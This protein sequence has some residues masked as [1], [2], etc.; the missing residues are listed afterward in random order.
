MKKLTFLCV[1]VMVTAAL[2]FSSENSFSQV[3]QLENPGFEEWDNN[4]EPT[5]WNS[6]PSANCTLGS[7]LCGTAAQT[8][9]E[10]SDDVRPGSTGSSCKIFSTSVS[11]VFTTITANGAL[12]SGQMQITNASASNV[13]NCNKTIT[14]SEE[15]NHR[16]NAKP[17][18]IV[19]WA[20]VVNASDDSKACCHLCIHD[21]YD[22]KD[23]LAANEN[24]YQSHIVGGVTSYDFAN[25]GSM[26]QRHSTPIIYE[27]YSCND[28]QFVLITFSTNKD[29]GGGSGGD[30]LYIDDIEFIYNPIRYEF[31]ETR[32][33]S[34]T[35][36]GETYT[37]SGNY[38]KTYEGTPRDSIVT[39][40][41]TINN[42]VTNEIT[43][44]ADNSFTWNNQ[45]YTTSGDYT[46]TFTA[47]N[48]CDSIVT[49]HLTINTTGINENEIAGT[50]VYPNPAKDR[51]NIEGAEIK[52]VSICDITGR[53]IAEY[54]NNGENT[55]N[56][57]TE[58]LES[59]NYMVVIKTNDGKST[60]QRIVIT[61]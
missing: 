19:F 7:A 6:F 52:S 55:M 21:N 60:T 50:N 40:H 1:A 15:F 11:V 9:H 14:S 45:Q 47:T 32:C 43:E 5:G 46:Q 53:E 54:K 39:L 59:G 13:N 3:Y 27:G 26:W 41:L 18:S 25:N 33:G 51:I 49:L 57:S 36:D 8:R 37:E 56:I 34:F 42:S 16:L 61:K 24:G 28:P 4:G 38:V 12:T 23:P 30:A 10:Q 17:D 2:I 31:S 44:T 35:W 48:G 29:A 20:K 22:L 58:M